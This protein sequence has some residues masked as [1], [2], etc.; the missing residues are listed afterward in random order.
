[1]YHGEKYPYEAIC[2][3]LLLCVFNIENEPYLKEFTSDKSKMFSSD[4]LNL[5]R[6]VDT[7]QK[8]L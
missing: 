6:E 8:L 3:P 7:N 5:R 4:K 2:Q 1:M